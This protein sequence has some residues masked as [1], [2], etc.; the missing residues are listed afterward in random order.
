MPD[1]AKE[2]A[3]AI[4]EAERV[5]DV[6]EHFRNALPQDRVSLAQVM[7]ALGDRSVGMLLLL[8][9][10]PTVSPVPLGISVLFNLPL[11]IYCVSLVARPERA[12]LPRWLKRRS[13]GRASAERLLD[14]IIPR[15]RWIERFL[16]PR[17]TRLADI[18]HSRR[19][20]LLC[21]ALAITAFVPLPLMGWLPGFALV[22]LALGLIE[23]DGGAVALG[24]VTAAAAFLVAALI[25]G[26]M[27]YAGF[28]LYQVGQTN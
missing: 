3:E 25:I 20:R 6:L 23:R 22:F 11:L 17:W 19:F 7:A 16:R 18:D 5:S 10:I 14:R 9:A 24:L 15:L 26:G 4:E 27:A 13:A 28:E 21:L 8:L 12:G 2:R 1:M